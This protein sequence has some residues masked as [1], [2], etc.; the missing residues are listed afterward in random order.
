MDDRELVELATT[1]REFYVLQ[2][3]D[4]FGMYNDEGRYTT[5]EQANRALPYVRKGTKR[6]IRVVRRTEEIMIESRP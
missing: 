1:R 2:R 3:E 6:G 4:V 5:L